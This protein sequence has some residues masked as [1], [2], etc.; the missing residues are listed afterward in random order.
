MKDDG[1]FAQRH[2]RKKITHEKIANTREETCLAKRLAN[3][4]MF[5]LFN[6]LMWGL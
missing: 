3:D 5:S 1:Y 2:I 4:I 6:F